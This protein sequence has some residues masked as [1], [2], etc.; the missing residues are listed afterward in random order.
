[1]SIAHTK[2]IKRK[3]KLKAKKAKLISK[4]GRVIFRETLPAIEWANLVHSPNVSIAKIHPDDRQ[5]AAYEI[6]R[7]AI[8]GINSSIKE[9]TD[10]TLAIVNTPAALSTAEHAYE[11]GLIDPLDVIVNNGLPDSTNFDGYIIC[12]GNGGFLCENGNTKEDPREAFAYSDQ[13]K[14]Q[15]KCTNQPQH[16]VSMLF[17]DSITGKYA[18]AVTQPQSYA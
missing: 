7:R 12:N 11:D 18:L 10:K 15:E 1:M 17:T 9:R 5:Q 4:Q 6:E 8:K 3:N 14:A 16:F 13:M 2:N